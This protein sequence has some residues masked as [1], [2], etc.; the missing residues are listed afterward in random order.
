MSVDQDGSVR[1]HIL[2]LAVL[3][4]LG[5]GAFGFPAHHLEGKDAGSIWALLVAGSN[6]WDNYR[7]Q[8]TLRF[9]FS[10]R[11]C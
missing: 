9:V 8:V 11:V 2:S 6:T 1:M 3:C 4:S 7:H 10:A 5:L